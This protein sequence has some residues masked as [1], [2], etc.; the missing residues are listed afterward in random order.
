MTNRYRLPGV[1]TSGAELPQLWYVG[2]DGTWVPVEGT[3]ADGYVPTVSGDVVVWALPSGSGVGGSA[4]DTP[5]TR[6]DERSTVPGSLRFVDG[7][8]TT[9][10]YDDDAGTVQVDAD[11]PEGVLTS[12]DLVLTPLTKDDERA[13]APGSYRLT[14]GVGTA[15]VYDDDAGTVQVD[16]TATSG[17]RTTTTVTTAVTAS[18]AQATGSFTLAKGTVVF[19]VAETNAR[20]CRVRLYATSAA[21]TADLARAV[22][23]SATSG[24]YPAG[25]GCTLDVVLA[26]ATTYGMSLDPKAVAGGPLDVAVA[27]L[28]YTV[29]NL[30]DVALALV[31]AFTHTPIET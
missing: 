18:G 4:V 13:T 14:D 31:V 26:A 9:V 8:S 30:T 2:T 11:V 29:D 7:V 19:R 17:V 25:T 22:T 21:R 10:V 28:Y 27:T 1:Q 24:E 23:A 12:G 15:V 16:S 5:L 3:P 20:A 6:D